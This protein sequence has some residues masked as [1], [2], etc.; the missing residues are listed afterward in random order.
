MKASALHKKVGSLRSILQRGLN[1]T[2]IWTQFSIS[3]LNAAKSDDKFLSQKR[4]RVPSKTRDKEI[5]RTEDEL[6]SIAEGAVTQEI[7]FS[8]F[9]YAVAQVEAFVGDLLYELLKFDN[10]R[11]QTKVKGIDHTMKVDVSE[12]LECSSRDELID[13]I[14]KKDLVSLFYASPA[15]QM[16][17]FQAV[18]GV[19]LDD[20]ILQKWIEIKATRDIVVHNSGVSNSTYVRKAGEQARAGEG[21]ILPLDDAYF[22][23]ALSVMKSFVGRV[24]SAIQKDLK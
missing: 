7:Y 3:A 17:Y 5:E 4:F 16:E 10:R 12:V 24:S 19:K 18:T 13:K 23:E 1:N 8:V 20:E 6:R 2:Y 11:I 14:I 21:E 15:L 22:A 9:V